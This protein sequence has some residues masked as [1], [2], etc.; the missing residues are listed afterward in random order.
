MVGQRIVRLL[1]GHPW[2]RLQAVAGSRRSA[3]SRYGEAV[4]WF[5]PGEPPPQAAEMTVRPCEPDGM[6]DC[7][8][9]FTSLDSKVAREVEGSF[10]RAGF[11]VVSN[12]SAFRMEPFSP[13]VIPE[14]N[15][16][17]LALL[18]DGGRNESGGF[19]VTNPNCSVVGLTLAIAP[20]HEAF[21]VRRIVVATMQ[22]LSG[23]G[24][25]GP[26]GI[27]TLDNILPFIPGEEEK[28]ESELAMLLGRP[29]S[30]EGIRPADI[31]VSAH[32]HR[33]AV[34]DGHMEA[35]SVELERE[36]DAEQAMEVLRSWRGRIADLGLPSAPPRPLEVRSEQDRPQPRIDRY[37]G[38]GM[39]VVIGR[40]RPCPV[41]T[42][43]MEVLSHNTIRG[44][45]GAAVLNGEL[46]AERGYLR[47]EGRS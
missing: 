16:D 45:G 28:L 15:P 43:R 1:D 44:A 31:A 8:V 25:G 24:T 36:A 26:R 3:G 17:H 14:V 33:V 35:V 46:L 21:G 18:D 7:D 39:T 10:V 19:I 6:G 40:V 42:L 13:L 37:A 30:G 12:S 29:V 20:L 27:E 41:F 32:C 22:A 9:V 4:R 34:Q 5:A 2:F 11:A 23:A 47:R 38:G